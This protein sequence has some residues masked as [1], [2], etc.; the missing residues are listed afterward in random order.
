MLNQLIDPRLHLQNLMIIIIVVHFRW[1]ARRGRLQEMDGF[2]A[3]CHLGRQVASTT[4]LDKPKKDRILS[5]SLNGP[6]A[7]N[8]QKFRLLG[9]ILALTKHH[10]DLFHHHITVQSNLTLQPRSLLHSVLHHYTILHHIV[11][12]LPR[13]CRPA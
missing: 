2:L 5:M 3:R 7:F 6:A 4:C 13:L 8:I 9:K 11:R 1:Q 10:L 12:T